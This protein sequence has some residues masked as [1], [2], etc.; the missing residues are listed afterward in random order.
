MLCN[1]N[2]A[3]WRHLP[4][5]LTS[6]CHIGYVYQRRLTSCCQTGG[7]CQRHDYGTVLGQRTG[8][9]LRNIQDCFLVFFYRGCQFYLSYMLKFVF[10]KIMTHTKKLFWMLLDPVTREHSIQTFGIVTIYQ[11][12]NGETNN[13]FPSKQW[14]KWND[15]TPQNTSYL[16]RPRLVP[17]HD[18]DI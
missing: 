17:V 2:L 9:E 16:H 12:R 18:I 11:G 8:S 6:Y 5:L 7:I 3:N 1:I 10:I 14:E 15:F 13:Y 4:R